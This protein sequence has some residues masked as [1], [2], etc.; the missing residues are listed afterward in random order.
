MKSTFKAI[1]TKFENKLVASHTDIQTII[2][3]KQKQ[4]EKNKQNFGTMKTELDEKRENLRLARENLIIL[5]N[6]MKCKTIP[7]H[8]AKILKISGKRIEQCENELVAIDE[9]YND[10]NFCKLS[11][12]FT[13][14]MTK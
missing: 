5:V 14:S 6:E 1:I 4:L 10:S 9:N 2:K 11:N 12:L 8:I 13:L 3:L 7:D